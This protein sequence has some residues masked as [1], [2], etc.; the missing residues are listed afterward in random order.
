MQ[1]AIQNGQENAI[2]VSTIEINIDEKD[3]V[4]TMMNDGNG[5]DVAQHPEYNIWIPEMIFSVLRT[6]TNYDKTEKRIVGGKN[7]FG[8]KLVL[9]W[10]EWGEVE[11]VD[12]IRG[13]KYIQRYNKNLDEICP[14]VITK[15][16]KKTKPYTKISFKPDYN[17]FGIKGLS[18]DFIDLLKKRVYDI[19]AITHDKMKIKYNN[20]LIPI[21]NFQQYVDLYI[22]NEKKVYESVGERWEYAVSLSTTHEFAHV[23]FVNGI[24]TSKGGKHVEYILYQIT[25]TKYCIHTSL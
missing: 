25:K 5:I 1:Q 21:K 24:H 2:P 19:C 7:G 11:T 13:L 20:Q 23:S 3:G 6:S 10:S 16:P 8:F 22:G 4:I 12:H 18:T 15:V 9:I 14:P 17:R